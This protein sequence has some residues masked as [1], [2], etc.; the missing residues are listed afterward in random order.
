MRQEGAGDVR[1]DCGGHEGRQVAMLRANA[2]FVRFT[3]PETMYV[4]FQV[5]IRVQSGPIS[6]SGQL[7]NPFTAFQCSQADD[8]AI[9]YDTVVY[10]S[11]RSNQQV[12]VAYKITNAETGQPAADSYVDIEPWRMLAFSLAGALRS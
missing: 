10:M 12:R 5:G 11:N 7:P 8:G 9:L 4:V 1:S 6:L 2:G 3:Y